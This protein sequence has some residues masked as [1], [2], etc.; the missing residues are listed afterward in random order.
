MFAAVCRS[1]TDPTTP[2]LGSTTPAVKLDG[3]GKNLAV[4]QLAFAA[5]G[6]VA[7]GVPLAER[8]VGR[9]GPARSGRPER[10]LQS[11]SSRRDR[12]VYCGLCG[13]GLAKSGP[14]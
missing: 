10:P 12:T 5:G 3:I 8:W 4:D 9:Q 2:L 7:S 6:A 14:P 13:S 11:A 1:L